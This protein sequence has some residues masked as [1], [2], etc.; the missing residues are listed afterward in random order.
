M[1]RFKL[2]SLLLCAGALVAQVTPE[3]ATN[4]HPYTMLYVFG[5]SY[6]DSGAGYVDTN[7]PTAVVYLAQRLG[8]PFTYYGD[9]TS[10]GKGLNFA[11]SG[12]RTGPGAGRRYPTG[13]MLS[14]GMANQVA[15]FLAF[16][17]SGDIPK[18]DPAQ[19]MF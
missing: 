6:S 18:F 16:T 10:A 8:I 5:D 1:H 13:E 2:A 3:P 4:S 11:V 14:Y 9:P 12:A 15:D 19:T 17:K 7:G